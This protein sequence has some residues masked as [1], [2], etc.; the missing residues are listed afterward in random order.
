MN[1]RHLHWLERY[2]SFPLRK[3]AIIYKLAL[4]HECYELL[5]VIHK[6]SS[7]IQLNKIIKICSK[8]VS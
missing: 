7:A 1:I 3:K 4:E 2:H 6:F 8:K 5:A